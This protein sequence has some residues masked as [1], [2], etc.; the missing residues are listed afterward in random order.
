MPCIRIPNGVICGFAPIYEYEGHLFEMHRYLGPCAL[1]NDLEPR[2]RVLPGF[3]KAVTEWDA[4]PKSE[5]EKFRA[6]D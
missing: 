2:S 4:L 1:R 3:W 6:K 5:R